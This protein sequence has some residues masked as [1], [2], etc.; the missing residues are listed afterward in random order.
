M[1]GWNTC[2]KILEWKNFL[3]VFLTPVILSPILIL[4]EGSS[5]SK[6]LFCKNVFVLF[7]LLCYSF[8]IFFAEIDYIDLHNHFVLSFLIRCMFS[9]VHSYHFS[10]WIFVLFCLKCSFC[11]FAFCFSLSRF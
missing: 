6:I 5:V 2:R 4:G 8:A 3:I 9:F 7:F 10:S 11:V 1:A